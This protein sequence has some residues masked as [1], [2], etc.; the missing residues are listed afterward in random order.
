MTTD[1]ETTEQYL[2]FVWSRFLIC[3]CFCVTWLRT[4]NGMT[5]I[6]VYLLKEVS[7]FGN[8]S[9]DTGSTLAETTNWR[10]YKR[11]RPQISEESTAVPYGANFYYYYYQNYRIRIF[12]SLTALNTAISN[13]N[14]E[15]NDE[16][17]YSSSIVTPQYA[18]QSLWNIA[19]WSGV[20]VWMTLGPVFNGNLRHFSAV[21][22]TWFRRRHRSVDS[23]LDCSLS[24]DVDESQQGVGHGQNWVLDTC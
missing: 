14:N 1:S 10:D 19:R 3:P 11:G 17:F 18:L 23:A 22:G 9:T 5:L 12:V 15:L 4:W 21:A 13:N 6:V 2:T 16:V 20:D 7:D 24:A 8:F